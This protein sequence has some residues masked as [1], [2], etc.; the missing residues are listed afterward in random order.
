MI[1]QIKIIIIISHKIIF[2][3][4]KNLITKKAKN[5]KI[6][7]LQKIIKIISDNKIINKILIYNLAIK[8]KI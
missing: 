7:I 3:K 1:N 4:I 8:I 2:N 6:K 5:F